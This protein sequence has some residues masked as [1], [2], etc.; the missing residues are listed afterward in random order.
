MID[1][2]D[3]EEST[4]SIEDDHLVDNSKEV[5]VGVFCS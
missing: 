4:S 2:N 1:D 3:D 5:K